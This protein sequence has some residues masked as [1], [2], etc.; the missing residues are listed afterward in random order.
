MRQGHFKVA[1]SYILYRAHRA[2]LREES[3][4]EIQEE[5]NQDSMIVVTEENGDSNFW[6]EV[7]L[8]RRVEY[9]VIGLKLDMTPEVIETELRRSIYP[10]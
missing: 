2:R 6:D 7:D 8:K 4:Q 5:G 3:G 10:R 1:E 9:A